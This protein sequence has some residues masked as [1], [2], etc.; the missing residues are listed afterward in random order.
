MEVELLDR[1]LKKMESFVRSLQTAPGVRA[2][3]LTGSMTTGAAS[4]KSDIDLLIISAPKRLYTARFFVTILAIL[5]GNKRRVYDKNPAGKF[6]LNFSLPSDK[7]DILPH[8]RRCAGFHRHIINL[9]DSGGI[10]EQ[11]LAENSWLKDYD[12]KIESQENVN[13]IKKIFPIKS[14]KKLSSIQKIGEL[15]FYGWFGDFIEN[16]Q[17]KI[18]KSV[19]ESRLMFKMDKYRFVVEKNELR[20]HP[21]KR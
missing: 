5:S 3:I 15:F 17:F 18:Q 7:L 4:E 13:Q 20:L 14:S 12:V 10:F 9:W 21:K 6:C 8:D 16:V 19:V 2:V 11:I 1:R